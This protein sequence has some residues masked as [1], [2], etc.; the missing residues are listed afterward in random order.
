MEFHDRSL[1][2][3]VNTVII[4]DKII[5]LPCLTG[6]GIFSAFF[7]L[8]VIVADTIPPAATNVPLIGIY[9][10]SNMALCILGMFLSSTVV[11]AYEM[12]GAK[13]VPDCLKWVRLTEESWYN[14]GLVGLSLIWQAAR[15]RL[16]SYQSGQ[17]ANK[18]LKIKLFS[19]FHNILTFAESLN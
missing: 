5:D 10:L 19:N 18:A 3:T 8:L 4:N 11:K 1:M 9:H 15:K 6:I 13:P 14:K 16:A 2:N 7:L 12:D 17:S